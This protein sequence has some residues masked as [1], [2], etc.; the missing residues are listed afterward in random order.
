VYEYRA[1]LVRV[2]AGDTLD[3]KVDLGFHITHEIRVRLM[4]INA[5]ALNTAAGRWAKTYLESILPA[6]TAMHCQTVEDKTGKYG[7]YLTDLTIIT[8]SG[9]LSPSTVSATMLAARRAVPHT[10]GAYE[11]APVFDSFLE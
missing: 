8:T 11:S 7:R 10:G 3:L 6:G 4:G 5:P 2:V 1:E 9:E